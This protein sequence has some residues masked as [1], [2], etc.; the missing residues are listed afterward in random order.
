LLPLPKPSIE[1]GNPLIKLLQVDST[2][3][4]AHWLVK[5][6][7]IINGTAI[8]TEFQTDGRG[9]MGKNWQSNANENILTSIVLD[10]STIPIQNQFFLLA[11]IA[12]G[13]CEFFKEFTNLP[14]AIK[15]SNDIFINDNKAGGI[16]IETTQHLSVRYAIVGIGLNINAMQF[17]K[18]S[19]PPT[20][21]QLLTQQQY[22]I[23]QLA[24]VLYKKIT[25]QYKLLL[26]GNQEAILKAYNSHLYKKN[27]T[28][29]LKK[30]NIKFNCIVKNVNEFGEL[31][32]E[33][34]VY[35]KFRFGDVQWVW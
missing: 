13:C 19:P 25:D 3:N 29:T 31:V 10:I 2:N 20:S 34:S 7:N 15:W 5:Q 1:I 14:T 11:S 12:L 16:L 23:D 28:I 22:N 17:Q 21:L 4:Y 27:E 26:H 6:G 30:E 32:V 33:N 18:F 35:D 9:Q 24:T 8:L